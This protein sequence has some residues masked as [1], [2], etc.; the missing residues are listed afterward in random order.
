MGMTIQR[1]LYIRAWE[2]MQRSAAK[3]MNLEIAMDYCFLSH[4]K[5]LNMLSKY[6]AFNFLLD[7]V[8]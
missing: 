2:R 8:V 7:S 5:A 6:S 1:F 3:I 4:L